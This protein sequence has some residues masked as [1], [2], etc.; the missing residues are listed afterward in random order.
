M[1]RSNPSGGQAPRLAKSATAIHSPS[2]PLLDSGLRRNDDPEDFWDSEALS[3]PRNIIFVPIAHQGYR[4]HAQ[5]I[6]MGL[7]GRNIFVWRMRP[8]HPFGFRPSPELRMGAGTTSGGAV[9]CGHTRGRV[10]S[11]RI[12]VRTCSR[13]NRSSRASAGTPRYEKL[14]LWLGTANWHS[15][16]CHAPPRPQQG[17][18]PHATGFWLSPERRYEGPIMQKWGRGVDVGGGIALGVLSWDVS[19]WIPAFAGMTTRLVEARTRD[20]RWPVLA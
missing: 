14:E 15:G 2:P 1:P 7:I 11:S 16:L 6:K 8:H 19:A 9:E 4:R 17:T 12:R 3:K 18:S 13:T 5:G 20:S 10:T